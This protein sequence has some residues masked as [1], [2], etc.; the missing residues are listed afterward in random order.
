MTIVGAI[1][2][3]LITLLAVNI[4]GLVMVYKKCRE[5]ERMI[6]DDKEN[7]LLENLYKN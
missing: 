4:I 6:E 3:C 7:K 1:I 2:A 5:V